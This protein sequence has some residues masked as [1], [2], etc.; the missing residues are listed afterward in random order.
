MTRRKEIERSVRTA[1]D[2]FFMAAQETPDGGLRTW[3]SRS[4]YCF[5]SVDGGFCD[6][7]DQRIS[8]L[9]LQ[10]SGKMPD[11][12]WERRWESL[13]RRID[14]INWEFA[15]KLLARTTVWARSGKLDRLLKVSQASA[16][17]TLPGGKAAHG[18]DQYGTL[19]A[20]GLHE[21]P[22]YQPAPRIAGR[23]L[24]RLGRPRQAVRAIRP[25]EVGKLQLHSRRADRHRDR[26]AHVPSRAPDQRRGSPQA[27]RGHRLEG[28][29]PKSLSSPTG[30]SGLPSDSASTRGTPSC[31]SCRERK[32]PVLRNDSGIAVAEPPKS[33][34]HSSEACGDSTPPRGVD[35]GRVGGRPVYHGR[36]IWSRGQGHSG[37]VTASASVRP[38]PAESPAESTR[39]GS[40]RLPAP[41]RRS[42]QST[43]RSA[44]GCIARDNG[45]SSP[46][47]PLL[48]GSLCTHRGSLTV[49]R[50]EGQPGALSNEK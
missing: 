43:Q 48:F 30:A 45:L 32:P 29:G 28:G 25:T 3:K 5:A 22:R 6:P 4:M 16:M 2:S 10:H 47:N 24:W 14:R 37:S 12:E 7:W 11:G 19:L 15:R 40:F 27:P 46:G 26:R 13:Q 35:S 42:F 34:S 44:A 49:V 1:S 38:G 39:R 20:G 31:A 17:A 9:R 41:P 23:Q 21:G 18:V 36:N 8:L 33:R 50:G